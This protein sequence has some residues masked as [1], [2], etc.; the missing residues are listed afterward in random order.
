MVSNTI[1]TCFLSKLPFERRRKNDQNMW[2]LLVN[3][4]PICIFVQ[5]VLKLMITHKKGQEIQF[6]T[7]NHLFPHSALWQWLAVQDFLM[8]NGIVHWLSPSEAS[9]R[10]T[11]QDVTVKCDGFLKL[12][13][14]LIWQIHW[15]CHRRQR[16]LCHLSLGTGRGEL[17]VLR[18]LL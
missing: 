17:V 5:T 9:W 8:Q 2:R 7:N 15:S 18:F 13:S 14:S 6:L 16:A 4:S 11:I 1:L 3:N 10:V 12:E